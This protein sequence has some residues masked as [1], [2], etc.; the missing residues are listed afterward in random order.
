MMQMAPSQIT[1]HVIENITTGAQIF[2][3]VFMDTVQD[4]GLVT[5]ITTLDKDRQ[6]I[7]NCMRSSDKKLKLNI[8]N[9]CFSDVLK[10]L[11]LCVLIS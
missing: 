8:F 2:K 9:Y 1:V 10:I 11:Y 4:M 7:D 6:K 5:L 3:N